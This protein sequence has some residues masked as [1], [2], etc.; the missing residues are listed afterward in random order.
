MREK[1]IVLKPDIGSAVV[2]LNKVDYQDEMNQLFSDKTK[3]KTIKND[4]TLTR[5]KTVQNYLKNLYKPNEITKTEK[6]QMRPMSTQLGRAHSLPK[7]YDV[8]A[9]IPKF[10]LIIRHTIKLDNISHHCYNRSL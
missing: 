5:S 8:F 10:R 1:Y 4:P 6:K 7:I 3:F 9:N 2:L